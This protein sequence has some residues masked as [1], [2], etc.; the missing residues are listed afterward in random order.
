MIALN[1]KKTLLLG[2]L[3]NYGSILVS[4]IVGIISVPIG[5]H[6]FGP[7]RYGAWLVIGSILSYIR[8]SDFGVNL[9]TLTL[10]AKTS[11][12]SHHRIILHHSIN[13]LIKISI[14]S[15]M[16]I[17]TI[18]QLYPG[19]I[20]ILGKVP[21]SISQEVAAA[22]LVM[23][24]LVM[25]QLPTTIFVSAF[26]GLQQVY[27]NRFY[28]I[29]GSFICLL[30]LVVVILVGG[31]LVT[32]AIFTGIGGIFVGILS[33]FHLF[34]VHPNVLPKINEKVSDAP[35]NH[36]IFTS[37]IRFLALQIASLIISNTNIIVIS[38]FLGLEMVTPYA[39]TFKLFSMAL[40]II[41]A[42]T[43]VLWPI[44][45][46]ASSKG[47]WNYIQRTYNRCVLGLLVCGGLVWIGGIVFSQL[48][49]NIWAGP[50]AYGGLIVVFIFGGYVYISTFSG[51]NTGLINGLNPTNSV[52][53]F[54]IIEAALN[55]IISLLL[56][57][58][59]GIGGVAIGTFIASLSV[60]TWF[61]PLYI[62]NRTSKK[63]NLELKPVLIHALVVIVFVF[64]SLLSVL[65]L[66]KGYVLYTVGLV[67][68]AVYLILSW[69]VIPTPFQNLVK[70]Y[71]FKLFNLIK[72][73]I[74]RNNS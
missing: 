36:L 16:F 49:I 63:V 68:I 74:S 52:V 6:Y 10:M 18:S 72:N 60:N 31:N 51:S 50:A 30:A 56:V 57:K 20:G 25:I 43:S 3:S 29:L 46:H 23:S 67:I 53:L 7:I 39:V 28:A 21:L 69:Y 55:L 11:D 71:L 5:L 59:L 1:Y 14:V 61:L 66:P 45:S 24:I 33:G 8:I 34:I 70:N 40:V 38:F 13:L 26:S 42:V 35:S 2:T 58:P 47:D 17:I 4:V 54:G 44:Y 73:V 32:F 62:R 64:I 12:S 65:Y 22:L 41:N 15:I 9:S 48:I 37:G 27:W 19:W